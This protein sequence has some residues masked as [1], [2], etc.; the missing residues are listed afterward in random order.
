MIVLVGDADLDAAVARLNPDGSVDT[1]LSGDGR[2]KYKWG[3]LS[4]AM[5]VIVL[6]YGKLVLAGFT[7]P[8]GGNM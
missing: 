3:S 7:G 1:T 6:R 5:D 4:R 2:R 8:E